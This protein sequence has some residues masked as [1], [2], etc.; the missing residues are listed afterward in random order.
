YVAPAVGGS[1][2][3]LTAE[4]FEEGHASWSADGRWIYFRS[5]RSGSIQIWKTTAEG[6]GVPVPVTRSGGF[7]AF[8]SPDGS[9][10]YYLKSQDASRLWSL[11]VR[12][13]TEA[14]M[15]DVPPLRVGYWGVAEGGIY[16]LDVLGQEDKARVPIKVFS[17]KN[18]GVG[19]LGW[20]D[21]S[22]GHLSA[23]F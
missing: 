6:A 3:R 15:D 12:G 18:R 9:L 7:E 19:R 8:E 16:F 22:R 23:G 10:V 14:P 5:N 21:S 20:I 1:A 17:L 11:P 13:G 2:R 4:Q